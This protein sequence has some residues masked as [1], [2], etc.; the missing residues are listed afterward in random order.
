MTLSGGEKGSPITNYHV[1]QWSGVTGER[2]RE[3]SEEF[4]IKWKVFTVYVTSVI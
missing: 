3:R 2:G 4:T 1:G